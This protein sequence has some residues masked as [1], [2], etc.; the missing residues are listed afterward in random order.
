MFSC[1]PSLF[2]ALACAAT[3]TATT[4]S[5]QP[6][7]LTCVTE[8]LSNEL[9]AFHEESSRYEAIAR[10]RTRPPRIKV[11]V[12]VHVVASS[13]DSY[14]NMNLPRIDKQLAVL[15]KDFAPT[16]FS[17]HLKHA[18]WTFNAAW[19]KGRDRRDMQRA[20]YQGDHD[21]L[22]V[23]FVE[24]T[25]ASNERV[26]GHC[27]L[28]GHL[29]GNRD[30]A[31]VTA[32]T[33]PRADFIPKTIPGPRRALVDQALGHTLT[34][35]VGHWLGLLHTFEGNNCTGK[36]DQIDDTPAHLHP[37]VGCKAVQD[38]CPGQAG[39]DPTHNFMNILWESVTL[40]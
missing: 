40:V 26:R 20:L 23:Y 12:W 14:A 38:S 16:G 31:I 6:T 9:V 11:G 28:P 37:N 32:S 8:G 15:S 5:S 29:N 22:N 1:V 17:F 33:T 2:L 21:S 30:G 25:D 35:E 10:R 34:H 18:D 39:M 3:A 36:G 24:Q 27:P 19:A 4:I 13:P 7:D